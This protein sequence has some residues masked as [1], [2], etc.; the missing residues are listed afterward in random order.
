MG[1]Y[2]KSP[3]I[4]L[5]ERSSVS[6]SNPVSGIIAFFEMPFL[7]RIKS[8]TISPWDHKILLDNKIA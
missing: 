3:S 8:S 4:A 6:K 1:K 2:C 5:S 7:F